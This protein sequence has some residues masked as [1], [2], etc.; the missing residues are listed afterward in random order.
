MMPLKAPRSMQK[1]W[2]SLPAAWTV[3][4][5]VGNSED[6]G[7][8]VPSD[9]LTADLDAS[10]SDDLHLCLLKPAALALLVRMSRSCF[11]HPMVLNVNSLDGAFITV[12][13][14]LMRG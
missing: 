5:V 14:T 4:T 9:A 1:S 13:M 7:A 11:S 10:R 6:V 8:D 2:R 3:S 12:A